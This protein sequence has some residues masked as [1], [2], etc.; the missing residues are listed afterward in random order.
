M[1]QTSECMQEFF[2]SALVES[3]NQY[4]HSMRQTIL[5]RVFQVCLFEIHSGFENIIWTTK[6]ECLEDLAIDKNKKIVN[7]NILSPPVLNNSSSWELHQL[8]KIVVVNC[9]KNNEEFI[10]GFE[11]LLVGNKT[12][13]E[14]FDSRVERRSNELNRHVCFYKRNGNYYI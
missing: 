13:Y 6:L 11:Y 8:E 5:S 7:V 4:W 1:F 14:C 10:V 3:T 9:V 12:L 2:P